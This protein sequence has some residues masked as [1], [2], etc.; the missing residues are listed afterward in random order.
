MKIGDRDLN[1]EARALKQVA[2][3]GLVW[4]METF[5][6]AFSDAVKMRDK[7]VEKNRAKL[8][9][10]QSN[11]EQ[12]APEGADSIYSFSARDVSVGE[13]L[14]T[15]DDVDDYSVVEV[16]SVDAQRN[17]ITVIGK[18][19]VEYEF[20]RS[21]CQNFTTWVGVGFNPHDHAADR[22]RKLKADEVSRANICR[23]L[24]VAQ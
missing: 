14:L 4:W 16:K 21:V 2:K 23:P 17:R 9:M 1:A 15:S 24:E 5:D 19:G 11:I 22:V 18:G 10:A 8:E 20:R 6:I 7:V 12:S 13:L 3:L